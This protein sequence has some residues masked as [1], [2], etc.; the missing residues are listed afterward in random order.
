MQIFLKIC[1]FTAFVFFF[2]TGFYSQTPKNKLNTF[3]ESMQPHGRWIY[4]LDEESTIINSTGRYKNGKPV[5]KWVLYHPD[6]SPF[7]KSRY[8]K[9]KAR[10]KRFYPNGKREKK[11]WSYLILD[12]PEA[13]Y[14][15]WEGKWKIYN[16][17]G[18][19]S[20]IVIYQKGDQVR[21]IREKPRKQEYQNQNLGN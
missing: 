4:Y 8:F 18:K 11:G 17:K 15:Y 14:Y 12:D 13:I 3:N 5:G 9:Q 2:R 19:L 1:F 7:V 20:K 6:G 21:T 10:E 16:E